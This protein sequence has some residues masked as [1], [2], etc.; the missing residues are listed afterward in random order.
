MGMLIQSMKGIHLLV[1]RNMTQAAGM[2][3]TMLQSDDPA[4]I[5]ECLNGYR[6]KEK[7][8]SNLDSFTVP[9]GVPEVLQNNLE[10][11]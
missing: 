2:Y 4:I 5:V 3:N 11:N 10:V 8:P 6:Q 9:L 1:P 7:L